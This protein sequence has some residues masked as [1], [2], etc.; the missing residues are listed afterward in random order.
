VAARARIAGFMARHGIILGCFLVAP[1]KA[2]SLAGPIPGMTAGVFDGDGK[3][4]RG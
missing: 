2:C 1:I 3:P 4:V